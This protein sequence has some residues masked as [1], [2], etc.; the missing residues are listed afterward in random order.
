MPIDAQKVISQLWSAADESQNVYILLDTARDPQIYPKLGQLGPDTPYQCL[1]DEEA[2]QLLKEA[3]P[4][5]VQL[6]KNASAAKSLIE[7]GWGQ[8]WGIFLTSSTALADLR[9]HCQRLLGV[10]DE[11]GNPLYFRYYDPRVLRVYLPTCTEAEMQAILG[12]VVT[13]FWVESEDGRQLIEYP[14]KE[15]KPYPIQ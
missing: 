15:G 9:T 3:A 11:A 12:S 8:S 14:P 6:Q 5:L 7:A 1:F 4:Y 10:E 13:R 2:P